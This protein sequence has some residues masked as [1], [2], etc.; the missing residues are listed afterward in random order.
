[1]RVRTSLAVR[2]PAQV[3]YEVYA[4]RL[5]DHRRRRHPAEG[6]GSAN[7]AGLEPVRSPTDASAS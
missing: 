1:M 6:M 4:D 5:D 3:A 2:A 7:G